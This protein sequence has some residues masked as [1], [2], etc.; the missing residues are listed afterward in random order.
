MSIKNLVLFLY[1]RTCF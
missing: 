1:T